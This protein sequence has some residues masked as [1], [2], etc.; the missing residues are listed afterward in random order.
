MIQHQWKPSMQNIMLTA[1]WF[2]KGCCVI[3]ITSLI[4]V[5]FLQNMKNQFIHAASCRKF[6]TWLCGLKKFCFVLKWCSIIFAS[7]LILGKLY[8]CISSR[9]KC[10][11]DSYYLCGLSGSFVFGWT[12]CLTCTGISF[13]C[14]SMLGFTVLAAFMPWWESPADINLLNW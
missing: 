10:W 3:R 9:C 2:T 6:F 5:S 14:F 4:L 12:V 11:F 13:D 1:L 8:L 7:F